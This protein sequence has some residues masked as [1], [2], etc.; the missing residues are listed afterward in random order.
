MR[1]S[2]VCRTLIPYASAMAELTGQERVVARLSAVGR[3]NA[4]IAKE[5]RVSVRTVENLVYAVF[6]K[7]GVS[8]GTELLG[9]LE[10]WTA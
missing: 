2:D 3:S 7:C 5:L 1:A 10:R 9:V 6:A 8:S 4:A